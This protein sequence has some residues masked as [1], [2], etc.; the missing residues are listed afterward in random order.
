MEIT[1][2]PASQNHIPLILEMMETFYKIDNYSFNKINTEKNL[3]E[4][5]QSNNLGRLWLINI[6]NEVVGYIILTFGYSFEYNG[7]DSF[8][9]ELFIKEKFRGKGIG[10]KTMEFIEQKAIE[11]NINAIHLEVE[12]LNENAERLYK[13]HGFW[14]NNRKLMNKKIIK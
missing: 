9:D 14:S 6:K 3:N 5:I 11:L 8:I 12:M 13:K 2:F 10:G 1:F 4:F 7:R